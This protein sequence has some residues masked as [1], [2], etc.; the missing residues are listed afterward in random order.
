MKNEVF[1]AYDYLEPGESIFTYL[2]REG[3]GGVEE[4]T[5]PWPF[6]DR[7]HYNSSTP[8]AYDPSLITI[9]TALFYGGMDAL[10]DPT[11]VQTLIPLLKNLVYSNLEPHYAHLDFVCLKIFFLQV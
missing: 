3:G 8:P 5:R 11:D 1:Q 7:L 4:D 9:P 10:A 6:L 2:K